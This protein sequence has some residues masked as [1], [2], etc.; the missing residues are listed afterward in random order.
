MQEDEEEEDVEEE[1][2]AEE[3]P[4]LGFFGG[5]GQ[6][7]KAKQPAPQRGTRQIKQ[8]PTRWAAPSSC[9]DPNDFF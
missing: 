1:E 5:R 4:A 6:Q 7:S 3:R 2:E 9:M 8:Q